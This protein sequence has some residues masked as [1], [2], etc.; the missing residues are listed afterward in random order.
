MGIELYYVA[1][2]NFCQTKKYY[3]SKYSSRKEL[4]FMADLIKRFKWR[5]FTFGS[6]MCSDCQIVKPLPRLDEITLKEIYEQDP[7]IKELLK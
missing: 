6:Y 2:C 1:T 7:F 4:Y 5:L 3:S